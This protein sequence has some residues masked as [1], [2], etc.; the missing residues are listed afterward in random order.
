MPTIRPSDRTEQD[1]QAMEACLGHLGEAGLAMA[2]RIPRTGGAIH[3]LSPSDKRRLA[4]IAPRGPGRPRSRSS[5]LSAGERKHRSL[6][7]SRPRDAQL[8]IARSRTELNDAPPR[9]F[10]AVRSRS[11]F[12]REALALRRPR[13]SRRAGVTRDPLPPAA[14]PTRLFDCVR[15]AVRSRRAWRP[16]YGAA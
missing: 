5:L 2:L 16:A 9:V 4:Q 1:A 12:G 3:G 7:A 13:F 10:S 6:A 8:L 14:R 15:D 11:C